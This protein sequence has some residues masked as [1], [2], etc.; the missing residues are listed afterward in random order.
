MPL[1]HFILL[2]WCLGLSLAS[3]PLTLSDNGDE[4]GEGT[5]KSLGPSLSEDLRRN[6]SPRPIFEELP[7]HK[8]APSDDIKPASAWRQHL[9]HTGLDK[10]VVTA[11]KLAKRTA[12]GS[13]DRIMRGKAR[14]PY[15]YSPQFIDFF[16]RCDIT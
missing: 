14:T 16:V 7:T 13:Q 15:F 4:A 12:G 10:H 5:S 6:L 2:V 1:P 8:R 11:S 9:D 3:S